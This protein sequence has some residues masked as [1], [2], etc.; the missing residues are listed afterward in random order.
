MLAIHNSVYSKVSHGKFDSRNVE[1]LSQAS[2]V[3][4]FNLHKLES[5]FFYNC[6]I[7]TIENVFNFF[8]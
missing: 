6:V 8:W 5:G 4:Y 1:L 7:Y 3:V 2:I